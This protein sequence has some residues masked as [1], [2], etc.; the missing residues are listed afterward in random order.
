MEI[1]LVDVMKE[2]REIKDKMEELEKKLSILI[3]EEIPEEEL[4]EVEEILEACKTGKINT[5]TLGEL[6]KEL[7]IEDDV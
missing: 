1:T 3:E 4:K 6:K 5:Y 7:E 2:L